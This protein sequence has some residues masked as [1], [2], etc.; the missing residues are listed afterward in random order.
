M[1][2]SSAD[3]V[4]VGIS[5][6]LTGNYSLQ[7]NSAYLGLLQWINRVNRKG[8]LQC[9]GHTGMPVSLTIYDD[10]SFSNNLQNNLKTLID[11]DKIDIIFGPYST[12]LV[13]SAASFCDQRGKMMWNHGGASKELHDYGYE[14]LVSSLTPCDK[15]F[16]R[17]A[18]VTK[19]KFDS[20]LRVCRVINTTGEFPKSVAQGAVD[21]FACKYGSDNIVTKDIEISA[22]AP[23]S[24][25]Q[26]IG[27]FM[28]DVIVFVGS[29]KQD[30]EFV[31]NLSR[32]M[33]IKPQLICL[34]AA[35]LDQFGN[36][37][38]D[39]GHMIVGPSQWE[40]C[41]RETSIYGPTLQEIKDSMHDGAS[42]DYVFMQTYGMGLI[43]EYCVEMCKSLDDQLLRKAVND[44]DIKTVFGKFVIDSNNGIQVGHD[45]N[46]IQWQNG[47]KRLLTD[48]G[49]EWEPF[50]G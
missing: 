20:K 7:G 13:K 44:V 43:V 40:P 1:N 50:Y 24:V 16:L 14:L 15:Y 10:Q 22:A 6:S 19:V 12:N 2:L 46:L 31:L 30:I 5:L 21:S 17:L 23:T 4:K 3:Y 36:D 45:M 34:P 27:S 29:Y 32:E 8:G 41:L 33:M 49:K 9:E 25:F 35:G 18:E 26:H 42:L 37:A 47:Y 28:P 48:T 39:F 11:D 38:G